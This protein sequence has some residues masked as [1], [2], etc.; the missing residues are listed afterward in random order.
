VEDWGLPGDM[1]PSKFLPLPEF[2]VMCG[3]RRGFDEPSDSIVTIGKSADYAIQKVVSHLLRRYRGAGSVVLV[4]RMS[5]A[6][7]RSNNEWGM[8]SQT[9]IP[10]S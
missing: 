5:D 1:L 6:A 8:E 7:T 9:S 10:N 2:T 3:G 4:C